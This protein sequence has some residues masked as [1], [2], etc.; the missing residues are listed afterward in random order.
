MKS[1]L[2][3]L[4]AGAALF[5][6]QAAQAQQVCVEPA[7][8][9]DGILYAMPV[10]Y[11]AVMASCSDQYSPDGF[12]MSEGE[13]FVEGFRSKQ[14]DAWPGAWR[15]LKTFTNEEGD[16]EMAK[17]ISSLPEETVRPFV[18]AI[19]LQMVSAEIKPDSCGKIERGVELIAP[20]PPENVSALIAFIA[21]QAGVKDPPI[22]GSVEVSTGI[23]AE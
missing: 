10:L 8:L 12:M 15:F 5:S 1:L 16:E 18:D 7:D 9:D 19:V 14:D 21:E 4:L 3:T 17:M 13:A 22:C 2:P 23:A 20:L 11:E 6:A